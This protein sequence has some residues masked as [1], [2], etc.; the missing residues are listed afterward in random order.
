MQP[1][2]NFGQ[3]TFTTHFTGWADASG[4]AGFLLPLGYVTRMDY[5]NVDFLKI[6]VDAYT[7]DSQIPDLAA[8]PAQAAGQA[9]AGGGAGGPGGAAAPIT[10]KQI[11]KGIWR[12]D[13][14]GTMVIELRD[15]LKIFELNINVDSLHL[16][17]QPSGPHAGTAPGGG[18]GRDRR[19]AQGE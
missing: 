18:R 12:V 3:V 16:Q 17:P 2:T 5:R 15:H 4:T 19:P 1:N 7:V 14:G 6:Y 13:Q 8:P 10:S 9:P 11:G